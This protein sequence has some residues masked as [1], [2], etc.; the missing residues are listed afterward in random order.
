MVVM[1]PAALVTLLIT[2]IAGGLLFSERLRPDLAGLLVLV[3]LGLTRIVPGSQLF[4]GF[5]GDAVITIIAI[6]VISAALFQ[7]GIAYRIST[8]I[9]RLSGKSEAGLIALVMLTAA[10]LSLFMN[11]IAAAGI[12]LPAAM[13]VSRQTDTSPSRLMMPLAFGTTLGGMATLLTTSNIIVSGTL[14]QA[15]FAPFSLLD[16]FPIGAPLVVIGILYMLTAGRKM[17]H[18]KIPGGAGARQPLK[19]D[20]TELYHLDTQ[21]VELEVLPGSAMARKTIQ[22]GR[23]AS[24]LGVTVVGLSRA[25]RLRIAPSSQDVIQPGDLLLVEGHPAPEALAPA[26]IRNLPKNRLEHSLTDENTCLGEALLSPHSQWVGK[27]LNEIHFRERYSLNVLA[28]WRSGSPINNSL[29]KLPLQAGDTLLIQGA[30]L[31]MRLLNED[32]DFILLEED[33]DAVLRP[34]KAWLAGLITI[35]TLAVAALGILP[36]SL[37]AMAGAVLA[38]LT[39]CLSMG[40]AY[41]TIEWRA[42]FLIAGMWPLSIAIHDTGLAA[43]VTN[44]VTGSAGQLAPLGAAALLL[45]VGLVLTQVIGGQVAALILAPLAISASTALNMDP[46]G[47]AMAAALSSS[48]AF[49]TPIGHPVNIMVMGSGGYHFRDYLRVGAPLTVLVFIGVLV[50]LKLFWG[51]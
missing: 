6:S 17:L 2:L 25:G 3:S 50:G 37:A 10:G 44:L 26:G 13:S 1:N 35:G 28:I 32:P 39:G 43:S 14:R 7:T 5:S 47:L 40:D 22:E 15:G 34:D 9:H 12:L 38:L 45:L 4:S 8:L 29:G 18:R 33:P 23:W 49:I 11:N 19:S 36:V 48:L 42:V 41:R 46:R 20:L 27:S 21:L 31:S 51:L 24:V 16:F 30:P